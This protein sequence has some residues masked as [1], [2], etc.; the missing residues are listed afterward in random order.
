[1][2]K[3]TWMVNIA[4]SVRERLLSPISSPGGSMGCIWLTLRELL[5][6]EMDAP[7]TPIPSRSEPRAFLKSITGEIWSSNLDTRACNPSQAK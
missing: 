6:K 1:M 2:S 4:G 5:G 7:E 3:V